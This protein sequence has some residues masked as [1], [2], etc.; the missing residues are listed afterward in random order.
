MKLSPVFGAF[1]PVLIALRIIF[2]LGRKVSKEGNLRFPP[3]A[4]VA[5]RL[6]AKTEGL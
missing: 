4:G 6:S 2:L 3:Y 1:F 5:E